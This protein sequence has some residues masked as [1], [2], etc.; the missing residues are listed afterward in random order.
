M[1]EEKLDK[2]AG[3]RQLRRNILGGNKEN[4]DIYQ[5]SKVAKSIAEDLEAGK[6]AE[7]LVKRKK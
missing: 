3:G 2:I 4:T 7:I 6:S 1:A 5:A